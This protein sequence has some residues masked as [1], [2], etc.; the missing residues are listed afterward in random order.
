[1]VVVIVALLVTGALGGGG[2]SDSTTTTAAAAGEGGGTPTANGKKPTQAL[3]KAVDGSDAKGQA[4]FGRDGKNVV[5]LLGATGLSPAPQG[6]VLHR[7]PGPL[8]D[9]RLPLVATKANK[10]G[11]V[12]GRFQIAAQVLGL[13]AGGFD[14]M[15][16]SL[17]PDAELRSALKQART[18]KK[19]PQYGGTAILEGPVTGPIVEAGEAG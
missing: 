17:V 4:L 9:E 13:L 3:L 5:L 2:S 8:P 1:M 7:L 19:A 16:L 18:A 15:E 6:A 11:V 10:D 14:K 12:S